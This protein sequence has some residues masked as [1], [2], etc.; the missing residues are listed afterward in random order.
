MSLITPLYVVHCDFVAA[1]FLL[2]TSFLAPSALLPNMQISIVQQFPLS[3]L[4]QSLAPTYLRVPEMVKGKGSDC[5]QVVSTCLINLLPISISPTS[6]A[7]LLITMAEVWGGG[8]QSSSWDSD[9]VNTS[10]GYSSESVSGTGDGQPDYLGL[11][12]IEPLARLQNVLSSGTGMGHPL[13]LTG[14][15]LGCLQVGSGRSFSVRRVMSSTASLFIESLDETFDKKKKLFVIVKQPRLSKLDFGKDDDFPVRVGAVLTE[16]KI[17]NHDPIR[18]HQNIVHMHGFVWDTQ[19]DPTVIAPSLLM[20]Y[21]DLGTLTDYQ[22]PTSIPEPS[23]VK[24]TICLDVATGLSFLHSCGVIHGDV[25]SESVSSCSP[26]KFHPSAYLSMA[27]TFCSFETP[28][29]QS[30]FVLRSQTLVYNFYPKSRKY[31]TLSSFIRVF[32]FR[33]T[34]RRRLPDPTH[35]NGHESMESSR[36]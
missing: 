27:V 1:C 19:D 14:S 8:S 16:L 25:K 20:E 31:S 7:T 2:I 4:P 30:E 9:P 10:L 32:A 17:L 11:L 21:A 23:D 22:S 15:G 29:A 12:D 5:S 18:K 6:P 13:G 24:M 28:A 26:F 3:L 34:R 33:S 36:N 35:S